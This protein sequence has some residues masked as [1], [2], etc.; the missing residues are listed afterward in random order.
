MKV[1]GRVMKVF[2]KRAWV[3][4]SLL[5]WIIVG[6]SPAYSGADVERAGMAVDGFALRLSTSSATYKVGEPILL[7]LELINQSSGPLVIQPL[8]PWDAAELIV[9][10]NGSEKVHASGSPSPKHWKSI[11]QMQLNPGE[12]YAFRSWQPDA[13]SGVAYF[14]PLSYWGY[15]QLP[16]GQ[17]TI[18]A[19][20]LPVSA[21][22]GGRHTEPR[23][24][25]RS[26][27]V[28]IIVQP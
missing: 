8:T 18:F 3:A 4:A 1:G 23:R 2:R 5:A 9:L 21:Y 10:R 20:P 14:H 13:P 19:T 6:I 12:T 27:A 24:D 16:A 22:F 11:A 26:N 28:Q 25:D 7:K 17:Y 15:Q